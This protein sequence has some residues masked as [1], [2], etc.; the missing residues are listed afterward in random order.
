MGPPLLFGVA[1]LAALVGTSAVAVSAAR[2]LARRA[3]VSDFVVGLTVTSIGT[4]LPELATSAAAAVASHGAGGDEAAGMAVGNVLGSNVFLM[5]ALLGWMALVQGVPD[6]E[7]AARRDGVVLLIATGALWLMS[8]DGRVGPIDGA[9]L[10]MAFLGW[11]AWIGHQSWGAAEAVDVKRVSAW[12][13]RVG[14]HPSWVEGASVVLGLSGVVLSARLLVAQGMSIAGLLGV[15]G[16]EVGVLVGYGT[17]LPE[18]AVSVQAARAG[19]AALSLGNVVG[20]A[21]TNLLLALGVASMTASIVVSPATLRF[22]WMWCAAISITGVL[23]VSDP[24][25]SHRAGGG[26]LLLIF[27]LYTWLRF[28]R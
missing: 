16:E 18:L 26:V 2:R 3:R 20:S 24:R 6:T 14:I 15:P 10:V 28:A 25:R 17:S 13:E 9:A 19:A 21:I 27:A 7:A 5:G 23:L 4:S 1:A 12:V 22:D 11:L 8:V